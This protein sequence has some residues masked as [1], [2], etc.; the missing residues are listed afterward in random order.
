M[1]QDVLSRADKGLLAV[2]ATVTTGDIGDYVYP[3]GDE[4]VSKAGADCETVIGFITRVHPLTREGTVE[5][6][7]RH[8]KWVTASGA[9]AF[10]DYIKIGPETDGKQTMT[11][12]DSASD[13]ERLR[14]GLIWAGAAD[15]GEA[16]ALLY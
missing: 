15:G 5:T 11:K 2:T 1:G 13:A 16:I 7:F 10:G 8:E 12:W 3:T 14:V 9:L 6:R 4:T